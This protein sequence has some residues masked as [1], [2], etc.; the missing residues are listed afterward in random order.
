MSKILTA[1]ECEKCIYAYYLEYYGERGNDIW[2]ECSAVNVKCLQRDG[3][4][5]YFKAH[6]LTGNVNV[7]IEKSLLAG[8]HEQK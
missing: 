4:Y 2:H 5:I 8:D 3:E 7:T 1:D 6:I